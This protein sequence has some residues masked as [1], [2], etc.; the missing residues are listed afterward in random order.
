MAAAQSLSHDVGVIIST[1]QP[2]RS[3]ATPTTL[4]TRLPVRSARAAAGRRRS[5]CEVLC[6]PGGTDWHTRCPRLQPG[7]PT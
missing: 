7:A 3:I 2:T 5:P 1:G 4:S 6:T